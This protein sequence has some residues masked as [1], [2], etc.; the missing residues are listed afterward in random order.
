MEMEMEKMLGLSASL[1]AGRK[2]ERHLNGAP[3][4]PLVLG[5]PN[6]PP[7]PFQTLMKRATPNWK[8][9]HLS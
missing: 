8:G 4:N 5:Q 7:G 1:L 9:Q 6:S 2:I 3:N